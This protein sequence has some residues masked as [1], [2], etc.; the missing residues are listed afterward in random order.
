[1]VA[2]STSFYLMWHHFWSIDLMVERTVRVVCIKRIDDG[3][4]QHRGIAGTQWRTSCD[5]LAR[6][7]GVVWRHGGVDIRHSKT[8]GDLCHE[9]KLAI[10]GGD[11]F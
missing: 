7:W 10:D 9:D 2:L 1:M 4:S 3:E 11:G 8:Y 6:G 5:G